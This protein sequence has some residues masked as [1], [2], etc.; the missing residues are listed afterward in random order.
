M[1]QTKD[2]FGPY[3]VVLAPDQQA[4]DT[5]QSDLPQGIVQAASAVQPVLGKQCMQLVCQSVLC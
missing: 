1:A 2:V 5:E 3:R 4:E